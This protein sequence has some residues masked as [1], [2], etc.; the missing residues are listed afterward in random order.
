VILENQLEQLLA[1]A[2]NSEN[3]LDY[4]DIDKFME[5]SQVKQ[6]ELD[7][8]LAFLKQKQVKVFNIDSEELFIEE[9][10][11]EI[12]DLKDGSTL[13][14]TDTS[15]VDAYVSDDSIKMYLKEIGSIPLLNADEEIKL[16]EQMEQGNETARKALTEANLRLVVSV[17]KRYVAGTGMFLLD[18]I[19]EGN[20][21]LIKAVEKFDYHKGYKFSTYAMWWIRQAI[22][23][24]IADQSKTIR[25]PVHMRET[26]N[27]IRRDSRQFLAEY[28]REPFPEE[29]AGRLNISL[30]RMQE[31]LK[32]FGDTVSLEAP[33]GEEEDSFLK[34]FITDDSMPEPFA[35]TEYSILREEIGE[36]LGTLTKREERILRLRFGFE[37]GRIRTLAEVGLEFN[38]T[39]ERIRQI[40]ARAIRRLRYKSSTKKLKAYIE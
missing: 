31:I 19:Q 17:A 15:I 8:I 40:E 39:R 37:D 33:I 28:G 24:A 10:A 9:D 25:I 32:L 13:D 21:G 38:V 35:E 14:D 34:D 30:D 4:Q 6:E 5:S 12:D 2:R 23:R 20:L 22:T 11:V 3:V 29:T 27:K 26:M 16:A 18:L 1:L 36:V 7:K